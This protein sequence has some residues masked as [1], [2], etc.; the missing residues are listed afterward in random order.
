MIPY[1]KCSVHHS[2][3]AFLPNQSPLTQ[4]AL[5]QEEW[6]AGSAVTCALSREEWSAGSAVTCA[7]SREEWSAGSTVTFALS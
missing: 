6:S 4:R 2:T 7:L 3:V 5:P 1:Q